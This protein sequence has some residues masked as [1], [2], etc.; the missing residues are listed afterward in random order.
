MLSRWSAGGNNEVWSVQA[1][2]ARGTNICQIL[3]CGRCREAWMLRW[4][5]ANGA[6]T[7][8]T[9]RRVASG[10]EQTRR[11]QPG[12]N[13]GR[14]EPTLLET[15]HL[16]AISRKHREVWDVVKGRTFFL[17]F[18]F[19]PLFLID[20]LFLHFPFPLVSSFVLCHCLCLFLLP[21]FRVFLPF[22]SFFLCSVRSVFFSVI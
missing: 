5:F 8:T 14:Y 22:V 6:S 19:V 11:T 16:H 9:W 10:H 18:F 12:Q 1:F 21:F 15:G 20:F 2:D 3:C 17:F 13:R 4:T 7:R